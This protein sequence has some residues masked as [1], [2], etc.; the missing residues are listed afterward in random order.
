M[1]KFIINCCGF[2]KVGVVGG[3]VL[4]MLMYFICGVYVVDQF[5]NML[6]GVNVVFG[7]NVLFLGFYVDEGV[8][9]FKVYQF[10]VKYLNGEGDGGMFF[11]FLFKVLKGNGIFGKKVIFVSGDMQIK[12]DVVCDSVKCMIEKEKVI[13]I[14]GGLFLVE[15]VVVQS[16]CQDMGV[17][18]MFCLMYF[19]DMIGK[20]KKCYGFCYFFNV[21]ML[22]VVFG[23]VF[24]EVYGKDCKVYYLIVDYIWGWIQEE[25]MKKFIEVQGWKMVNVVCILFGVGDFLQYLMLVLSLGV[26]VL[27]FNYYGKDM[28]NLLIQVV[29]FGM[30]QKQVGGKNFEIVVLF[31]FEFMVQGV[32]DVIKGIYGMV[33]W[34]WKLDNDG[35]KVFVKFFGKEYGMLFLQVVQMVYVQVI[36]YVDVC[37]CVGIF[38]VFVVIKVLEDFQFDGFGNGKMFYCGSDYQCFKDVL[39]VQGKE[40]LK[41]KFDFFEVKK[42]VFVKDVIYDLVIFGGDFGLVDVKICG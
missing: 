3:L 22:G 34:D 39:V 17:I 15:V 36:F 19:N 11:I 25:F 6:I 40:K 26:D 23:L 10:V 38:F 37:E 16:F 32:G 1:F 33:N 14:I 20:D 12:V 35:I 30:C 5:C 24:V 21:Y 41:D 31:F 4:L 42:I 18:F 27:I 28:V 2:L 29:Q 8:D 13:M 9:E 7:F